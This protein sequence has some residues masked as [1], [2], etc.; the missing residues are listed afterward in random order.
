MPVNGSTYPPFQVNDSKFEGQDCVGVSEEEE[1]HHYFPW[2]SWSVCIC[3]CVR[4]VLC[5]CVR[6]V[7]LCVRRVCV[8]LVCVVHRNPV[9]IKEVSLLF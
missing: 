7:C 4:R 1:G 6:R 3:L 2:G 8:S 5:L 9:S